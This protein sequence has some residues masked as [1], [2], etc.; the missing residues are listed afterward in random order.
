M[1]LSS[2]VSGFQDFIFKPKPVHSVVLLRILLSLLLLLNWVMIWSQLEIF[3]GSEGLVSLET[4]LKLAGGPRFSLFDFFPD[5]PGIAT[6]V[7]LLHLAGILGMLF[8]VFTRVSI[9]LT[10][11]T[12]ISF[13]FRNGFILNSADVILRNFLFFLIFTPSGDLFSFDRWWALKRGRAP[14]V[15]VEKSPWGL[16]LLQIQFCLVYISTV[17]FKIQG[18]PWI[19]GTAVYYA[20]RLDEFVRFPFAVL[21]SL[22]LIKLLTWST[23]VVEFAL[24]TL[25]WIQELRYWVLLAGV[26]LHIGIDLTMNIPLFE[27]LMIATM[28]VMMDP[29]DLQRLLNRLQTKHST[30][31][32]TQGA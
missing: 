13:H 12:L 21:N 14:L 15:P 22:L 30:L 26:G 28:T 18:Q 16:R 25:V 31:P 23:L 1:K 24:G 19:D 4:T 10:F 27:W 6:F 29:A 2:V 17:L 32:Q 20:T 8:G 5:R 11:L 9:A 7:A 3:W